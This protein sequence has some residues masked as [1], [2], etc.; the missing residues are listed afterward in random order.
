MS[1]IPDSPLAFVVD[2]EPE[3]RDTIA[4]VLAFFGIL[5]IA[6]G[7]PAAVLEQAAAHRPALIILDIMMPGMDGYTVAD[8]PRRD[9][10]TTHIPIVFITGHSAP[11]YRALSE[12]AGA[13]AHVQKPFTAEELRVAVGRALAS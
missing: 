3:V 10:R 4:D 1:V 12:E 11:L 5:T 2:D 9:P 8:Q 6:L 7:E 13:V